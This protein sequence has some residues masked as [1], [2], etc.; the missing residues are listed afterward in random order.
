MSELVAQGLSA[1][2]VAER[3]GRTE[4]AIYSRAYEMGARVHRGLWSPRDY[5]RLCELADQGLTVS[6]IADQMWRTETSVRTYARKQ[7]VSIA[8][9]EGVTIRRKGGWSSQ[10]HDRL[11][12]LAARGRTLSE[13]ADQMGRSTES[14]RMHARKEGVT[15]TRLGA[16]TDADVARLREL[17]AQG[18][19]I[20]EIADLM[21]RT[22]GAVRTKVNK[23]RADDKQDGVGSQRVS[24]AQATVRRNRKTVGQK[25]KNAGSRSRA[26]ASLR[27]A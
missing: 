18:L 15:I 10:E 20:Q 21:G 3:L 13:I 1:Q 16:W 11:C 23:L 14:I 27:A 26:D 4:G 7:S 6:E 24:G 5:V 9:K 25:R 2:K 12:E 8:R 19:L 22:T 17:A